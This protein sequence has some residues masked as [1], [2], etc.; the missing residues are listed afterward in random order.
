LNTH[1]DYTA[2]IT[3]EGMDRTKIYTTHKSQGTCNDE[4]N[5][6]YKRYTLKWTAKTNKKKQKTTALLIFP[7]GDAG[8]EVHL[9]SM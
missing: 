8:N 2:T 7:V 5:Q 3:M 6:R 4:M 9:R 1:A